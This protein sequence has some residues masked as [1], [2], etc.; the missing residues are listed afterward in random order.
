MANTTPAWPIPT[1]CCKAA[2][3]TTVVDKSTGYITMTPEA[4]HDNTIIW[5][6]GRGE[7]SWDQFKSF[8]ETNSI[9]ENTKVIF[10]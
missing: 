2:G 8:T 4:R 10:P 9:P 5:L 6:H 7:F 3:W 1:D